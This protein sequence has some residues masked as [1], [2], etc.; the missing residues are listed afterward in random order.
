MDKVIGLNNIKDNNY[1]NNSN[2]LARPNKYKKA[3]KLNA[4][5]MVYNSFS[6]TVD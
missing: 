2:K 6:H 4:N 1:I 5:K 3:T